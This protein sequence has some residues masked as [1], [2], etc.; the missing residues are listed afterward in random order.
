METREVINK[1][2]QDQQAPCVIACPFRLD[3]RAFI[4]KLQRGNFDAAY[5]IYRDSVGFP[6][7]VSSLCE[8]PCKTKCVRNVK[9]GAISI[10]L[11][12][13]AIVSCAEKTKPNSYN[14]SNKKIRI[15]IIGAGVSG[16]ACALRLCQKKYEVTI[17]EKT[18]RIG[19]HLWNIMPSQLF[20]ADIEKQFMHEKYLIYL[21]KEIKNIDELDFTAIYIATG[22]GGANFDINFREEKDFK[23]T[24][25]GVF[26][27][28]SLLGSNSVEAIADGLN[29]ASAIERYIKTGNID[30]N[31]KINETCFEILPEMFNYSQPIIPSDGD[32]YNREEA[33]TEALR[34]LKCRCNACIQNCDLMRIY[35][36][37]P[38]EIANEIE[39]TTGPETR[40][41]KGIIGNRFI[42]SCNQCGLCKE[43]CPEDIDVGNLLITSHRLLKC[44]GKMP[45]AFHDFW[46]RDMAFSNSS[47]SQLARIPKG[48][49]QS[50]LMFFPGCQLGAS[51][52]LYVK[53]SYGWLL[54]HQP[55][56]AIFLNC[57][58]APAEWAGDE[59][60]HKEVIDKIRD[61]WESLGRPTAVFA[62]PTCKQKFSQYIPEIK[63]V[64]LYDL[65]LKWKKTTVLNGFNAVVSIFDP[66]SS[67]EEPDLQQTIR[68]I[69]E[70]SGFKLK[71]LQMEGKFAQ[72]C[73][74]GG[75]VSIANPNY[76]KKVIESRIMQNE[77]PYITYCINCR[78]TFARVKKPVFHILD[79]L[80]TVN[81]MN[82][83]PPTITERRHNRMILKTQMLNEFWGGEIIMQN[84]ENKIGLRIPLH[85]KQKLNN[86]FILETDI[87]NVVEYCESSGRKVSDCAS[88]HFFGHLKIGNITYWVEYY[89]CDIGF[90]LVNAYSHRMSIEEDK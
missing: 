53:K 51:N 19:G 31:D 62:C 63:G 47:M 18:N 8:E 37:Y 43:I 44:N 77:Y 45:W 49:K 69:V 15:A 76:I 14:M 82:H 65:L 78:D 58:G 84:T 36:K 75:Q 86:D 11:L 16:L 79:L 38:K 88:G 55:N 34:C 17:Y 4:E 66:C 26:C 54:E 30:I 12:E 21:N 61:S 90:E 24:K 48:Y 6:S 71:P 2:L 72:C 81:D 87:V 3:I 50:S 41:G 10:R 46:L 39:I 20:L 1:C 25:V 27:G 85:L 33:I 5:K 22:A 28:G 52:P 23:N 67:R 29:V 32:G 35:Q 73:S 64:F 9:D 89:S 74:W 42:A 7:I 80:F 56:T 59:K 13:E 40:S 83:M 68:Q 60:L 57:C 70:K